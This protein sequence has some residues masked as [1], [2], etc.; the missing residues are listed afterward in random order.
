MEQIKLN[1]YSDVDKLKGKVIDKVRCDLD[2][3]YFYVTFDDDTYIALSVVIGDDLRHLKNEVLFHPSGRPCL[4]Y[5]ADAYGKVHFYPRT[6]HA[7][8]LG[9][10]DIS[11]EEIDEIQLRE[12][13]RRNDDLYKRYLQLKEM[14]EKKGDEGK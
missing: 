5:A 3:G 2:N 8:D 4:Y 13:K 10:I 11:Q 14:F 7:I 1:D 9:I 6:Q 12:N